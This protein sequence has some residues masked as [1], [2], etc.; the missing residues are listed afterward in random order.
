VLA[1]A[2]VPR[3]TIVFTRKKG[4]FLM[5]M[6]GKGLRPAQTISFLICAIVSV[7]VLLPI[8]VVVVGS[9]R[10]NGELLNAP[11]SW[12]TTLHWE[13]YT[14]IIFGGL[15][16]Q[17][18][19]NSIYTMIGTVVVLLAVTCPA[20]FVLSRI[21]FRGRNV[22]FNVF[23][24]GLLFP[25]TIAVLPLY[26]TIRQLDLLDN[27]WGIILPQVAFSLPITILILWNFFRAVPQ[28]LEDAAAIDGA[29]TLGFFW[30]I[31]LPLARPAIA[32]VTMLAM[33]S[34][35]NNFL[36]PLLVLNDQ[37]N[38][39][40]PLGA[41]Q[42]QGQYSSDWVLVLAFLTLAMIPAIIIYLFAE[43]QMVAGLTAGAV[44]G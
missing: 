13:N 1:T 7:F 14:Q 37:P 44:K 43:R 34:S 27:L 8:V 12:P 39:T 3:F 29:P 24:L 15:F 32:V 38:W 28:E 11:F 23:L 33:V 35:W 26:I 36:L 4:A 16:W 42:F 31:L 17:E 10:T 22:V 19:L 5:F 6:P 18:L 9:L 40:L 30:Y 2:R 41:T 25:I 21:V 20:A